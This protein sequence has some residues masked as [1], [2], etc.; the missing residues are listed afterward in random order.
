VSETPPLNRREQQV[1][2]RREQIIQAAA[3]L[4]ASKGF[5][6]TTTRDIAEAAGLSEGTLYNYYDNKNDLLIG[7]M[8]MLSA[9]QRMDMHLGHP[10]DES[11]GE[12]LLNI[13]EQRREYI[14]EYGTML[15]SI[16]SEILVDPA[17]RHRYYQEIVLPG[18]QDLEENYQ[19]RLEMGQ[20]EGFRPDFLARIVTSLING[21]YVLEVLGDPLVQEQWAAL[22]QA[23]AGM[24]SPG[25]QSG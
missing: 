12:F 9:A 22:S 19:K 8:N 18:L 5:H 21:L 23:A 17:L 1:A 4:F 16:L 10:V 25:D 24:L 6:R 20:L 15:Q 2:A 13:L 7:I 14:N 11:P 3:S